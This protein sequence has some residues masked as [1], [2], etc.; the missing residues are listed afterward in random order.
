MKN[1]TAVIKIII[2]GVLSLLLIFLMIF[3]V[4]FKRSFSNKKYELLYDEEFSASLVKKL[5]LNIDDADIEIVYSNNDNLK[6]QIF[7][8]DKES[9]SVKNQEDSLKVY[10]KK[11]WHFFSLCFGNCY[12]RKV[13]LYL[14]ENYEGYI[15]LDGVNGDI[16][17]DKFANLNGKIDTVSGDVKITH[18]KDLSVKTVSGE[19][20]IEKSINLDVETISGDI[21]LYDSGKIKISTVSGEISVRSVEEL[22]GRST[23]GD[24]DVLDLQGLIE[25][26]TT[27]G[28]VEINRMFLKEN[29][30]ISSISGDVQI[31]LV[32]PIYIDASTTSGDKDIYQNDRNSNVTLKISTTSGDIEVY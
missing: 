14:P 21:D 16:N 28:E 18:M 4:F 20:L 30:S 32:T 10:L 3:M 25:F 29:S 17:I 26:N 11:D 27:S 23:S 2:F 13:I 7:D 1:R 9:F 19:V 6:L 24:L 15:N 22:R 31:K 12:N 5:D 8:Q